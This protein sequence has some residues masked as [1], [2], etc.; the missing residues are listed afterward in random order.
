MKRL[1]FIGNSHLAALKLGWD[2]IA[3]EVQGVSAT[4][5]GA[6]APHYLAFSVVDGN[7]VA[8]GDAAKRHIVTNA[9]TGYVELGA[10]DGV[11]LCGLNVSVNRLVLLYK[12]YRTD[13]QQ[14]FEKAKYILSPDCYEKACNGLYENTYGMRLGHDIYNETGKPVWLMPQ[15]FPSSAIVSSQKPNPFQE[16]VKNGDDG[17]ILSQ[18]NTILKRVA[19][20]EVRVLEQPPET[21]TGP[22][23]SDTR[24]SAGSVRLTADLSRAH[25]EDDHGHMNRKYGAI[26]LRQVLNVI[27]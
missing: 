2:D 10:Y 27:N 1:C 26:V 16:V 9:N 17:F 13:G 14:G 6:P 19:G 7:L 4:F 24:Y 15:P 12:T 5:F 25:R 3:G 22:L 8:R 20:D 18:Y 23:L 21:K 11:I